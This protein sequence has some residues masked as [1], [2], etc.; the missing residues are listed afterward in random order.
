MESKRQRQV[1]ELIKRNFGIVLQQ[2]GGYVY[3]TDVLVTV[4]SVKM[5]PDFSLAKIYVSVYNTENK[6]EVILEMEEN[7][8]RLKQALTTRVKKHMRRIPDISF[9]LD[10]TLDE[11]YRLRQL[12]DRL[13]EDKQMGDKEEDSEAER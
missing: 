9:F 6:Q 10:D 12:F 2:E 1:S 11:M 7:I 4:T 3:G 5:T 8:I 13:H